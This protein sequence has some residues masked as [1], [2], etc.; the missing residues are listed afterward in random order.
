[1]FVFTVRLVASGLP[2]EGRLELYVRGE[3]GTVNLRSFGSGDVRVACRMLGF[4]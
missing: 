2:W 3:W 1:M 4:E